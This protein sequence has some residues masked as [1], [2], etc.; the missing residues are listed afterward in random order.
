M[1]GRVELLEASAALGQSEERLRL[2]NEAS[3]TGLWE[4]NM[5]DNHVTWSP[6][7]YA[8]YGMVR[9]EFDG[10]LETFFELDSSRRSAT[11]AGN[12]FGRPRSTGTFMGAT[13][14]SF[15]PTERCAG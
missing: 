2:A 8:I 10:T 11:G 13:S 4:W 7:C 14:A 5:P 3:G 6:E 1:S 9:G 12:V 15:V